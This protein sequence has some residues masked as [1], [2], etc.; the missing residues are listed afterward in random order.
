MLIY[1]LFYEHIKEKI[2]GWAEYWKFPSFDSKYCKHLKEWQQMEEKEEIQNFAGT[3][4]LKWPKNEYDLTD[5]L[6]VSA[7]FHEY[8]PLC[9]YSALTSLNNESDSCLAI[10]S[11]SSQKQHFDF[12][13][14]FVTSSLC[15]DLSS[16]LSDRYWRQRNPP[17]IGDSINPHDAR[18]I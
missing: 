14:T 1:L 2:W 10:S 4:F 8:R 16:N 6:N 15:Q 18:I 11:I 5:I 13:G 3:N 7:F 17:S 12:R 9:L